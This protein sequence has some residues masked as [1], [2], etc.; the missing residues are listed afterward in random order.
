MKIRVLII[1]NVL[2]NTPFNGNNFLKDFYIIV[3]L[4]RRMLT[5]L[6]YA[7]NSKKN[8]KNH[9]PMKQQISQIFGLTFF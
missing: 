1:Q 6:F 9:V 3:N 4:M 5:P 8:S 2:R 7:D